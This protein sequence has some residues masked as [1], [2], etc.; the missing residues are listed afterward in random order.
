MKQ[1]EE[2]NQFEESE[3]NAIEEKRKR[4]H[5]E[6]IRIEEIKKD[7]KIERD[8]VEKQ[9]ETIEGS[10]Y[11]DTKDIQSEKKDIEVEIDSVDEQIGELEE[12][13]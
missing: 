2:I 3:T 6:H 7:L 9:L 1:R 12:K 8:E 4:L 11:E 5:Y 10:V 13:L